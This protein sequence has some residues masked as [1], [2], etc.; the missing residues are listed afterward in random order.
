MIV[1]PSSLSGLVLIEPR[2]FSDNRG[3]F[4]ESWNERRF[5]AAGIA[6]LFVQANR[7]VSEHRVLRGFHFQRKHPQGQLVWVTEGRIFDVCVDIRPG[8]PTFGR[9]ESFE[10]SESPVR[11]VYMPPGFAHGFCVLSDRAAVHYKC[12]DY[13]RPDDEGGIAWNDPTLAVPWPIANPIVSPRDQAFPT[14]AAAAR[15]L[16]VP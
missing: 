5:R 4:Y 11:Q 8:S 12:T 9:W 15:G 1:R 3:S 16:T 6:A 13:Y 7:S 2:F 10:L 14:F